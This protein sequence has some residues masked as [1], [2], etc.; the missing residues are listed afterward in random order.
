MVAR[1]IL[2]PD[3][4][5]GRNEDTLRQSADR[6]GWTEHDTFSVR[7]VAGEVRPAWRPPRHGRTGHVPAGGGQV[8]LG[9]RRRPR[10]SLDPEPG[11]ARVEVLQA[12]STQAP[13]RR[14]CSGRCWI[15]PY[16]SG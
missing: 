1:E 5:I 2:G 12:G 6:F 4:I 15:P 10:G 14:R 9:W 13:V 16:M 8:V 7:T 11:D 3:V